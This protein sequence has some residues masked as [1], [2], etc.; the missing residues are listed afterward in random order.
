[1]R[2]SNHRRMHALPP[3][4][5]CCCR[6]S[7]IFPVRG[8]G[9]EGIDGEGE[10]RPIPTTASTATTRFVPSAPPPGA[11]CSAAWPAAWPAALTARTIAAAVPRVLPYRCRCYF[12][13]HLPGGIS[14]I[15]RT[16]RVI[17]I[18]YVYMTTLAD[19]LRRLP[20]HLFIHSLSDP[21]S[22]YSLSLSL[23]LFIYIYI[24]LPLNLSFSYFLSFVQPF[25]Y[26]LSL[27]HSPSPMIF[28]LFS[29]SLSTAHALL[30]FSFGRYFSFLCHS[31]PSTNSRS[32]TP[33]YLPHSRSLLFV[34]P[35]YLYMLY[36]FFSGT[37][38]RTVYCVYACVSIYYTTYGSY[39][40]ICSAYI[41]LQIC[42][43]LRIFNNHTQ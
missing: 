25:F 14:C 31:N 17:R 23:S 36:T 33:G 19:V 8:G 1:M 4:H 28:L 26:P 39:R 40:N 27:S 32:S 34:D 38:K 42:S 12:Y 11:Q 6:P 15:A 24:Y 18:V 10:T 41:C 43:Q 2:A 22:S 3:R 29:L 30:L 20:D 7:S 16:D 35:L 21:L 9:R 13:A 5:R 37:L